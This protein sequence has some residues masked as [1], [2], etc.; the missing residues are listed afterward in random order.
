MVHLRLI[1]DIFCLEDCSVHSVVAKDMKLITYYI[2]LHKGHLVAK[3]MELIT[4]YIY[5]Q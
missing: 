1:Y 4:Y 2:S 5:L 3:D